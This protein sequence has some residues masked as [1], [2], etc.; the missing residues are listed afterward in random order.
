MSAR[1]SFLI[2]DD[3]SAMRSMIRAM[4]AD[5]S[6]DVFEAEDG[7]RSLQAYEDHHPDWV[8]MD[9]MMPGMDGLAATEKMVQAHPEARVII[10]THQDRGVFREAARVAGAK[11][12]VLKENLLEIRNFV[13]NSM[14]PSL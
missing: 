4:I 6:G 14:T 9:L 10:V 7:A 2:T 3:S 5:I 13:E 8:L 12:Y 1:M 11:G